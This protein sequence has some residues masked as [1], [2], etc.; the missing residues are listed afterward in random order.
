MRKR[1]IPK[2]C[3]IF[4]VNQSQVIVNLLVNMNLFNYPLILNMKR[5]KSSRRISSFKTKTKR[6]IPFNCS[7]IPLK[8]IAFL[9]LFFF[10]QDLSAQKVPD[11]TGGNLPPM[12][13]CTGKTLCLIAG[14]EDSEDGVDIDPESMVNLVH[15][16]F[17]S[18]G[19]EAEFYVSDG[20]LGE[21]T[22]TKMMSYMQEND[23][24]YQISIAWG[25]G[26]SSTEWWGAKTLGKELY[27]LAIFPVPSAG[28]VP[29]ISDLYLKGFASSQE[30]ISQFQEDMSAKGGDCPAL[31]D[32]DSPITITSE[33]LDISSEIPSGSERK[34]YE[35]WP[36]NL[37]TSTLV[38]PLY[39]LSVPMQTGNKKMDKRSAKWSERMNKAVIDK[40][41][42][43]KRT[44]K[45]YDYKYVIIESTEIDKYKGKQG[46]YLLTDRARNQKKLVTTTE[47]RGTSHQ[48]STT[49]TRTKNV[50][51]YRY[52][53]KDMVTGDLY[54]GNGKESSSYVMAL[55][56]LIKFAEK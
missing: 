29:D 48:Y 56:Y 10:S 33:A 55:R 4:I 52:A 18:L 53:L 54:E 36:N 38:V 44:M 12:G 9:L 35:G 51:Y 23:Y 45:K 39:P 14:G 43:L 24:D 50:T 25:R 22:S 27:V 31:E 41:A 32:A 30:L 17:G 42:N 8:A 47:T 46:H 13:L 5:M 1:Y 21:E 6:Q 37:K 11:I 2:I 49:S 26:K 15:A 20:I 34:I 7:H 19:V 28:E 16:V 40:N 3:L